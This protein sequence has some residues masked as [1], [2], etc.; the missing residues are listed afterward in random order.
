MFAG[1]SQDRAGNEAREARSLEK[2]K[3]CWDWEP[4]L[5]PNALA[6]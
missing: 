2:N 4:I 5:L 6:P 3:W 1:L